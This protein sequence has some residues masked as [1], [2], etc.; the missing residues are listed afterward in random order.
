MEINM[1]MLGGQHTG[2]QG[3]QLAGGKVENAE[4][5]QLGEQRGVPCGQ[6]S[7]TAAQP[8]HALQL[9]FQQQL[10][11][12]AGVHHPR[13]P[14]SRQLYPPHL[15]GS[16]AVARCAGNISQGLLDPLKW[17]FVAAIA[18]HRHMM[19]FDWGLGMTRFMR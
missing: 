7:L 1:C 12:Q 4:A 2:G 10:Q 11:D 18:P 13:R 15:W 5:L 14:C 17:P 9:T 16:R 19:E 8:C 3:G 6:H